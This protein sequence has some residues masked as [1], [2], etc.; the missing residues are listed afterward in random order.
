MMW[1]YRICSGDGI[2]FIV[3]IW[4][5]IKFVTA[6]VNANSGGGNFWQHVV[7]LRTDMLSDLS[8]FGETKAA[9]WHAN[10]NACLSRCLYKS[11]QPMYT[12]AFFRCKRS[13]YRFGEIII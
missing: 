5:E 9:A 4:V 8:C 2:G 10:M 12:E 13:F 3:L 6:L 7:D 1:S 11:R